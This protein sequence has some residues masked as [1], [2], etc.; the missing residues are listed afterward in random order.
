MK[1]KGYIIDG[2]SKDPLPKANIVI[3]DASGKVIGDNTTANEDG[4]FSIE[5]MP[6]DHLTISYLGYKNRT[7]AV[8][9][10]SSDMY[11][12]KLGYLKPEEK[13]RDLFKQDET[14][15]DIGYLE[16]KPIKWYYWL[17]FAFIGYYLYTKIKK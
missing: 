12:V 17:G 5:V 7:I 11:E 13:A 4:E 6:A 8:K 14:K 10:M 3:T 2:N 9:K 1:A 15:T 16:N